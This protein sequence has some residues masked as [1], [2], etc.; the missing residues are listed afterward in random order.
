MSSGQVTTHF[1]ISLPDDPDLQGGYGS[2]EPDVD[3]GSKGNIFL[4]NYKMSGPGFLDVPD[5]LDLDLFTVVTE[6]GAYATLCFPQFSR[7]NW[8]NFSVLSIE[9]RFKYII[10]DLKIDSAENCVESVEVVSPTIAS[11]LGVHPVEQIYSAD[12]ADG[13]AKFN[14]L[15]PHEFVGK[16]YDISIGANSRQGSSGDGSE[17]YFRADA[18]LVLRF[19]EPTNFHAALEHVRMLD[20]LS[21]SNA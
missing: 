18:A 2:Y 13:G 3:Y 11:V 16:K 5:G 9:F 21:R 8:N 1:S 7:R 19:R 14:L 17:V 15:E 4:P 10:E 20:D 6:R 12:F